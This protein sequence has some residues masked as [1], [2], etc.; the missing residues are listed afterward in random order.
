MIEH[1][2]G[3]SEK[4]EEEEGLVIGYDVKAYKKGTSSPNSGPGTALS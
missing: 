4:S 2:Y 1:R 3:L